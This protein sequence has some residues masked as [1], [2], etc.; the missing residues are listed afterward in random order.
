MALAC[1]K[2]CP[3]RFCAP[4]GSDCLGGHCAWFAD[5]DCAIAQI[6]AAVTIGIPVDDEN[7]L[8][9]IAEA[10]REVSLLRDDIYRTQRK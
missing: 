4:H 2:L 1:N 7:I 9:G 8:T 6:A 5:G 10:T 3:L